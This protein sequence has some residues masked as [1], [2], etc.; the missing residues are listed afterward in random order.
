MTLRSAFRAVGGSAKER[1]LDGTTIVG[2]DKRRSRQGIVA[3]A[4]TPLPHLT[5]GRLREADNHFNGP[6]RAVWRRHEQA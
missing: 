1:M 6:N 3:L 5:D 2:T 4:K